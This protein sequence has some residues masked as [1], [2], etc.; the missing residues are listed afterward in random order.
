MVQQFVDWSKK[1]FRPI[2]DNPSTLKLGDCPIM[3]DR[4]HGVGVFLNT[5]WACLSQ[6]KD[7]VSV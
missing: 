2:L 7:H 5:V 3:V 6:T 4:H 1:V